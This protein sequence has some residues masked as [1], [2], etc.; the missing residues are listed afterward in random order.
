MKQKKMSHS[1]AGKLGALVTHV[2]KYE[3]LTE[4]SKYVARKDDLNWIA[5]WKKDQIARLL[6]A[7]QK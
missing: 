1:E 6:K 4:L 7:Y 2:E 3:M 5:T